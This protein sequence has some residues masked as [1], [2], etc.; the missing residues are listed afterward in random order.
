MC[1]KLP[2]D[3]DSIA[4]HRCQTLDLGQNAS[5]SLRQ[6][7]PRHPR[8]RK[9]EEGG[10]SITKMRIVAHDAHRSVELEHWESDCF[11]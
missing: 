10:S 7:C 5:S 1:D 3:M 9:Q 6:H 11:G 8:Q 2:L 4:E